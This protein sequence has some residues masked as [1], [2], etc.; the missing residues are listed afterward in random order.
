MAV[1]I[2]GAIAA[3]GCGLYRT[4]LEQPAACAGDVCAT[5][6]ELDEAA[7]ALTVDVV[8]PPALLLRNAVLRIA[9]AAGPPC[10]AGDP[11]RGVAVDGVAI[12]EGPAAIGGAHRLRLRFR[13]DPVLARRPHPKMVLALDVEVGGQAR[14]LQV[15]LFPG[16]S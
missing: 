16:G 8:G 15:S 6:R 2:A 13:D 7:A 14:C 3:G 4:R 12:G 9:D 5:P 11:V 10:G 1:L